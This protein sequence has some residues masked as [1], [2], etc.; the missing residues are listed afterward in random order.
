MDAARRS[1]FTVMVIQQPHPH[2]HR[3]GCAVTQV[4]PSEP[5]KLRQ[6]AGFDTTFTLAGDTSRW[7]LIERKRSSPAN[8]TACSTSSG[9]KQ[10]D[11]GVW[12]VTCLQQA[13]RLNETSNEFLQLVP[14]AKYLPQ[15][16]SEFIL[17]IYRRRRSMPCSILKRPVRSAV[18]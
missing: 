9:V 12:L 4:T 16:C 18:P 13:L 7:V 10:V 2:Q 15:R 11:E 6:E 1:M 8:G 5:T 17:L 14:P 3:L